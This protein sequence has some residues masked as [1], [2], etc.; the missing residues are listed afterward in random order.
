MMLTQML[1]R[2]LD[3]RPGE[4][5]RLL[6][7]FFGAYSVMSFLILSRA[8]REALY[9]STFDVTTL[10][11]V[12]I[13]VTALSLPSAL[14]FG[15]LMA[16]GNPRRRFTVYIIFL[17]LLLAG[18]PLL[19][20]IVPD[21]T[22]VAFYLITVV[23]SSLLTSGFWMVCAEHFSL[24]EAKRLFGLVGAGG[25][26]GAMVTGVGL[27][28][29]TD[30]FTSLQLAS[31]LLAILAASLV[32]HLSM[33]RLEPHRDHEA[34]SPVLGEGLGLILAS[35]HLRGI[36][37]VVV[38]GTMASTVLDYQFKEIVSEAMP[39][40]AEMTSFFGAFYGWTGVVA[41]LVQVLL[42]AR[43]MGRAGIAF[44]LA[45]LPSFLIAGSAG[46]LVVPSLLLATLTRGA[47]NALRK[48]LHRSVIEYLYMAVPADLRRRTKTLIDS[49]VDNSAS[50]VAAG[51]LF[52]WVTW[53]GWPSRYLSLLVIGLSV[54]FVYLSVRTGVQ[55]RRTVRDRL[56]G[57]GAGLTEQLE[58]SRFDARHLLTMTLTR[59]D[60]QE[61]LARAG[62]G[63]GDDAEEIDRGRKEGDPEAD[64]SAS[65]TDRLESADPEVVGR[66]LEQQRQWR[67]RHVP[68]L[69]RLLARGRF[70]DAAVKALVSIGTPAT[71]HA[72]DLLLDENADFVIRRRI[73]RML[74]EIDTEEA[75]EA[76]LEALSAGRFEVR[77]RAAIAL[78]RRRKAGLAKARGDW[79]ATV[80]KAVEREV[81]RDRPIWELQK[82]L[83]GSE[84]GTDDFVNRQLDVRGQLS[85]EHTFRQLSLVLDH[86]AVRMA[87]HGIILDDEELKSLSL[88]YLEQVLPAGIREKLWPFIGDISDHQRQK[89][90]RPVGDVVDE[91]SKTGATLFGGAVERA[92]LQAALESHEDGGVDTD[93]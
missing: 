72:A 54:A 57:G 68:H 35:P 61:E 91:L 37:A 12:T 3:V 89:S 32:L 25:T 2:W 69:T 38:L 9:L 79:R 85:L 65:V 22:N 33:P 16:A 70:Y 1:R 62:V 48:S 36:A 26:L 90:L 40:S 43:L 34:E 50:G 71:R 66:V 83:D 87:F 23:G 59:L 18:L 20:P 19:L 53:A 6:L 73:P 63:T 5:R 64:S 78:V 67:K 82:I 39:S 49:V 93:E 75:D 77:Y 58:G 47:D 81:S 88:E 92:A 24:R 8:L 13:A 51:L 76:L 17:G 46:M 80:W 7:S 29:L 84:A 31:G 11:Y 28:Q 60:L 74:A 10:P 44:S 55:Y 15:R 42:A 27:S 86:Q 52:V 30:Y 4:A 45:V 41:L 56:A 21:V 14:L